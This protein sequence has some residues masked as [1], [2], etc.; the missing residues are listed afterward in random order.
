VID[1]TKFDS[2]DVIEY[3]AVDFLF[4]TAGLAM[5]LLCLMRP[6]SSRII[7]VSTL[8]SGNQLQ[9]SPLLDFA[10]RPIVPFAFRMGLNLLNQIRKVRARRYKTEYSYLFLQSTGKDLDELKQYIED[11]RLR[12]VIGTIADIR[13][14]EAVRKACDVVYCGRGG[15]GKLVIRV[16]P[17]EQSF[18][19]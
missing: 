13:D 9:D 16:S 1:Y 19:S 12:T 14:T 17:P 3:G 11:G 15:L 5:E 8:P 7:S 2:R 18:Q 10:Y 6:G 4:D